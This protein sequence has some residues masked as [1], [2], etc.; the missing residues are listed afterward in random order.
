MPDAKALVAAKLNDLVNG[1]GQ[2]ERAAGGG[3][4]LSVRRRCRLV[5]VTG[6]SPPRSRRRCRTST[7]PAGALQVARAEESERA[8]LLQWADMLGGGE[9]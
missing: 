9:R 3:S 5:I 1:H 2:D 8:F 6:L 4:G 7:S